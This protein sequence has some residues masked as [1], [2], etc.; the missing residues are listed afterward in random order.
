VTDQLTFDSLVPTARHSDPETSH[1]A[2]ALAEPRAKT[3]RAYAL[4]L[5]LEAGANGL[6]DFELAERSGIAQTSIGVRRGE[7]VKQGLAARHPDAITRHSPSGASSIV[8]V[9]S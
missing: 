7:L 9:A 5:L 6:T 3:N 1:Q 4:R 8:W 2:A